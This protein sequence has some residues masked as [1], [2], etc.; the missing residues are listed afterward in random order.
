MKTKDEIVKEEI[1]RQAQQLFKQYG[2]KKTTMDE[3]AAACGKAKSTLYHYF[4]NKEEVFD[5]VLKL[6]MIIIREVVWQE[7]QKH[8]RLIDKMR[9]YFYHFHKETLDKINLFRILKQEIKSELIKSSRFNIV[10]DY[11]KQFISEILIDGYEKGE[12]TGIDK[13]DIPWF[14]GVMLVAFL[15]IIRYSVETDGAFNEAQFN[16]ISEVLLPRVFQ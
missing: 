9:A 4:K 10:I 13:D 15:G 2:L 12:F 8:Q 11:E 7:V 6:E 5:E 16:R 3:I 1:I 14:T